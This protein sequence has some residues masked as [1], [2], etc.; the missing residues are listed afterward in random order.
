MV[1][2]LVRYVPI[3][4]FTDVE[5]VVAGLM[6]RLTT[7]ATSIP[8]MPVVA[9]RRNNEKIETFKVDTYA[10]IAGRLEK[11]VRQIVPLRNG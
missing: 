4:H 10:P 3:S 5:N 7:S 2:I 6:I 11:I 1:K 9:K 8:Q